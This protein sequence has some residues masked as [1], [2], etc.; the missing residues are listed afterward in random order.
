[1]AV[2]MVA[3]A[4]GMWG[5]GCAGLPAAVAIAV[6]VAVVGVWGWAG[7]VGRA[8][9]LSVVGV[10][11]RMAPVTVVRVTGRRPAPVTV[12]R[13]TLAVSHLLQR[14]DQTV[15]LRILRAIQFENGEGVRDPRGVVR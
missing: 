9:T 11:V 2:R 8:T 6:A 7:V 5:R 1:M 12:V 4:L 10:T 14:V 3:V 13:V 15:G